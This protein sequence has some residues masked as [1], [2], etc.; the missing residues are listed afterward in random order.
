MNRDRSIAVG[1]ALLLLVSLAC[2]WVLWRKSR[3][4]G[5]PPVAAQPVMRKSSASRDRG[6]QGDYKM[7]VNPEKKGRLGRVLITYVG[8]AKLNPDYNRTV[9]YKEGG[10]ENVSSAYGPVVCELAPGVYDLEINGKKISGIPVKSGQDTLIPSGVLR[11][12]GAKET[13]FTIHNIGVKD[14]F[15]VAYGNALVGLPAGDYEIE[16]SGSREKFTIEDGKITDF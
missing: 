14:D 15:C 10:A 1:L 11:L 5:V 13:R 7:V 12:H 4:A 2:N 6:V 8:G 9:F 16:I 3:G